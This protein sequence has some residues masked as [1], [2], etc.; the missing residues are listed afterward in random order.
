[1]STARGV[2]FVHSAPSALC[3]HIEWALATVVGL[4]IALDWTP[5]PAERSS[6]RAELL[7]SGRPGTAA[8]VA[9]ALMGWQHIRFEITED[10]SPG[11][12]GQRYSYT[13]RLGLFQAMTS[14]SGDIAI[15]EDRLKAAVARATLSGRDILSELGQLLGT[16]WDEELEVFRH[17]GEGAPVRWLTRAV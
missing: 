17:A 6:Y 8:K 12:D 16:A 3:P 2:M 7:W 9:S 11:S 1:M 4:P 5:Q 13:P 14:A 10:P 15:P